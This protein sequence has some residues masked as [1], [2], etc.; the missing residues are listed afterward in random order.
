LAQG[1]GIEA[2]LGR[3]AVDFQTIIATLEQFGYR[4]YYTLERGGENSRAEIAQGVGF[5]RRV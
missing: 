5:L 3:G 1:R 4:G 2:A